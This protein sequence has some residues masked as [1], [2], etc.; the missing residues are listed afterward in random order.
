MKTQ[1]NYCEQCGWYIAHGTTVHF[2]KLEPGNEVTTGQK[3]LDIYCDR[4]AWV[5]ALMAMG[6]DPGDIDD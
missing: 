6:V 3:K 5:S 1:R 2:G 4:T